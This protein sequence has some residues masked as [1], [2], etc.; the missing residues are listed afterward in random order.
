MNKSRSAIDRFNRIA[1]IYEAKY[2]DV[3][4]YAEG[5]DL[6][7]EH[8]GFTNANIL[9]LGCGPGNIT[10]YLLN[11]CS[12]YKILGIDLAPNMIKL[13]E[14]NCPTA[15]FQIMD[16]RKTSLLKR[17][18]DA[19]VT[20]FCLPYLS[21]NEVKDLIHSANYL[22]ESG[23]IIYL[24][25]MEGHYS[26]SGIR[27]SSS[28]DEVFVYY[29]DSKFLESELIKSG[30]EIINIQLQ[31]DLTQVTETNDLIVLAKKH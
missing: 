8:L 17:T 25:T 7:C 24:S 5:L 20:G 18:F 22:L 27:I 29:H 19:I 13:A 30:F 26:N 31:P 16:C 12:E 6:F 21:R 2:M 28:G 10:Q 3:A 1:K 14:I 4:S 9:E 15:T 11:C 23:G